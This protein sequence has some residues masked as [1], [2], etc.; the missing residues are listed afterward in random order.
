M[1]G[2]GGAGLDGEFVMSGSGLE[3]I[4]LLVYVGFSAFLYWDAGLKISPGVILL[5]VSILLALIG[6]FTIH[7]GN[8][9]GF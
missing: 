8:W 7:A 1:Q 2:R 4:S 9:V 6:F 3:L 5:F